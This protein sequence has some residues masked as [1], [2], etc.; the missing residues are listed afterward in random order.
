MATEVRPAS[1]KVEY[2][3]LREYL[4]LLESADL[5]HRVTAPVDLKHEIGAICARS[6]DRH[7]PALVFENVKGYEGIPFVANII[8]TTEQVAIAFNTTPDE[9]SI[10]ARVVNGLNNR[11]P[12]E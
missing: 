4:A 12:S 6:L 8:S 1:H 7:G 2:Q 10:F 11:I 9:E 3:D 5:L